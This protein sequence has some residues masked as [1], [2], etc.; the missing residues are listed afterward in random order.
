MT[1]NSI[2]IDP[3]GTITEHDHDDVFALAIEAF[4]GCTSTFTCKPIVDGPG[5]IFPN[6]P[7]YLTGICHD[8]AL[9]RPGATCN[10]KAWSLY[11]RS[12]LAGPIFIAGWDATDVTIDV[13]AW[14][15]EWLRI[16]R[17]D[18]VQP[19]VMNVDHMR[20]LAADAGLA[21]PAAP[22]QVDG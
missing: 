21:W 18:F 6:F 1:C 17:T 11:G 2:R 12:P 4:G 15:P 3:D 20:R 5:D 13:D 14:L 7:M 9:T 8:W 22:V 10:P 19:G 16:L